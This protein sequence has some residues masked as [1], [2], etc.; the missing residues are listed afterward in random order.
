MNQTG[1]VNESSR[2]EDQI[3]EKR[4]MRESTEITE[5]MKKK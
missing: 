2:T 1:E 4:D 3:D 5:E